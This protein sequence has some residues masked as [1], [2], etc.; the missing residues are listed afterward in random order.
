[1]IKKSSCF[2]SVALLVQWRAKNS[3]LQGSQS[4]PLASFGEHRFSLLPLGELPR[5]HTFGFSTQSQKR[6]A[7]NANVVAGDNTFLLLLK[8]P[9]EF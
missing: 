8:C 5:A 7:R 1:M 2:G 4:H 3:H 9:A 6:N